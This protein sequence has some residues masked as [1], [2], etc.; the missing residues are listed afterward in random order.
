MRIRIASSV[1][2][3][4]L[5]MAATA[6]A[7]ADTTRPRSSSRIPIS[8]EAPP[9]VDTVTVYDTVSMTRIDTLRITRIDTVFRS[10][11]EV[12]R[13]IIH[14]V[15]PF[16]LGLATGWGIPTNNSLTTAQGTGWHAE[17]PLGWDP[18]GSM[19]GLRFLGGYTHYDMKQGFEVVST[20]PQVFN[21][22]FDLKLHYPTNRKWHHNWEIYGVGGA[23]YNRFKNI[24]EQN[25]NGT[26]TVGNNFGLFNTVPPTDGAWH[27]RWGWNAG[28]G[29]QFGWGPVSAYIESRYIGFS[30]SSNGFNSNTLGQVPIVIGLTGWY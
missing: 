3:V 7:Q 11:G 28:G 21:W 20:D 6:S 10:S 4:S 27:G 26:F 25:D 1:A 23:T 5:A 12:A 22:D 8:K 24:V 29:A 15:G 16:Y 14:H 17:V 13:P 2:I 9:R 19:L 18:A 30:R